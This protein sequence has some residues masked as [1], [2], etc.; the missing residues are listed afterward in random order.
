MGSFREILADYGIVAEAADAIEQIA[1]ETLSP[2]QM[3]DPHRLQM[4]FREAIQKLVRVAEP[5]HPDR[6]Q[7]RRI[8]LVGPT[9]VGKTTTIA[10]LAAYYLLHERSRIALVTIDT[11]RIAAVEQLK[12]YGEIMNLPVE[13][14]LSPEQ[15]QQAFARHRDKDLILI[16]TAGRSPRDEPSLEELS[17][18]LGPEAGVENHLVLAVPTRE[19]ELQETVRRFSLLPLHNLIFTKIDECEQRGSILNV[20]L[21][22]NLPVSYL[23]DGQR[24]P[25]DLV[26]A[27][28]ESV[29][30]FIA[31]PV[32]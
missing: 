13:V 3:Q 12:V 10:K 24:V 28:A 32:A 23:T 25:E 30:D 11:Y 4:F 14:V 15:L 2:Q 21:R 20:P 22:H 19:R 31:R 26:V 7:Q 6:Q 9:G 1:W 8:A 17:R 5:L 27:K 29:A 18:F 16:D